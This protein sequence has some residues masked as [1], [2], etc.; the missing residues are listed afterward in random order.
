MTMEHQPSKKHFGMIG[1]LLQ[2]GCLRTGYPQLPN[3][4]S[5]AK[6]IRGRTPLHAATMNENLEIS[7]ILIGYRADTNTQDALSQFPL[8]DAVL[9]WS[10]NRINELK[11]A[12]IL[13]VLTASNTL[14]EIGRKS[15]R[16]V[17]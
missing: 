7:K 16:A 13:V 10:W 9:A 14:S 4:H 11:T 17:G 12:R 5:P 1:Q 3:D 8:L 15:S 2:K 6:N